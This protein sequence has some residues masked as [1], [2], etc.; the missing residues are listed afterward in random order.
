MPIRK[1]EKLKELLRKEGAIAVAFS[2]GVDSTYLLHV[3]HEVLGENV[4]AVT[5]RSVLFPQGESEEAT[6]FCREEGIRQITPVFEP[7]KVDGF[8]QNPPDRCYL[9]KRE[10]FAMILRVASE[11]GF[12]TVADG[13]NAD[14]PG[15]YRPGM[16]AIKELGVR[17]PLKAVGLTKAEIREL[18]GARGLATQNKPSYACLASRFPYG[19]TIEEETLSMVEH[20]EAFLR[21]LGFTQLRVRIHG[22]TL[23]RIEVLP[24]ELPLLMEHREAIDTELARIGFSYSAM[25]LRGYRTGSMNETLTKDE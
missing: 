18:S 4:L 6:A 20:G 10:L 21:S 11:A 13:S 14:D 25:D 12:A 22:G 23:A 17:S 5:V 19:E 3:A 2:G 15:D 1:E 7:L 9:C 24:A 16:R 8:A